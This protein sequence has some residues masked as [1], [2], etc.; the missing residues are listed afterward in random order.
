MGKQSINSVLCV[1]EFKLE[2]FEFKCFLVYSFI[3]RP[4]VGP[5][6]PR[7]GYWPPVC[8]CVC[9]SVCPARVLTRKQNNAEKT[10][11]GV[12]L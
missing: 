9:L 11:I 3:T 1:S 7:Y 12:N 4:F 6:R 10:K 2:L 5:N 8:L